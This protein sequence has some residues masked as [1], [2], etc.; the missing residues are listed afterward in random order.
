M[1]FIW[2]EMIEQW[3]SK[4]ITVISF[5]NQGKAHLKKTFW[6]DLKLEYD[7]VLIL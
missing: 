4:A 5:K 3:Q 6:Y 1:L 7:T 2:V